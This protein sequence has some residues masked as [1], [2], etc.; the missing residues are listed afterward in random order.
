MYSRSLRYYFAFILLLFGLSH[1][2]L[3]AVGQRKDLAVTAIPASLTKGANVVIRTYDQ[4]V[5]VLDVKQVKITK[6]VIVTLLN[7]LASPHRYLAEM[8]SSL[9]T[10]D[11]IYAT[12]YDATGKQIKEV[13][14]KDFKVAPANIGSEGYSDVRIKGYLIQSADYPLTIEV[15]TV[16]TSLHTFMLPYW[17]PQTEFGED[18]VALESAS[19]TV[20]ATP[21]AGLRYKD[22]NVA[23]PVVKQVSGNTQ[24]S[25]KAQSIQAS[26][27]ESLRPPGIHQLPTVLLAVDN[28]SLETYTGLGSTWSGLGS[29]VWQ[30]NKGRDVLTPSDKVKVHSLTDGISDNRE[31]I[32]ALYKYVQQHTRYVGIE[33]GIGGWQTLDAAFV[34]KN[35]YGDCK[36]LS[37]YTMALLKEAGITSYPALVSAGLRYKSLIREFS[38]SCFNHEILCVPL[39]RDTIWLECTSS[40]AP[41][42]YLG[43]F[44]Q[45]RDV[46]LL[47]PIGG[48]IT[49]TPDYGKADNFLTRHIRAS[50]NNDMECIM[51][52]DSKYGGYLCDQI[53]DHLEH[54]ADAEL[55]QYVSNKFS[56][57]AYTVNDY[58]FDKVQDATV[59]T[60]KETVNIT[61]VGLASQSEKRFFLSLNL[62]P[63]DLPAV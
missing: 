25:W 43:A 33:L 6:H 56:L 14:N 34:G 21:G 61:A 16:V 37:N 23:P 5:D 4:Q 42:G 22:F 44:T 17:S 54:L 40:I 9:N 39:G 58:R 28:I 2:S 38:A 24:W 57:A 31:K 63:L 27:E 46:L 8:F 49:H 3:Y 1:N 59:P 13:R 26:V 10:L 29:F 50:L 30:M 12:V 52:I 41:P 45:N 32:K 18:R 19:L 15:T 7:P 35:Q 47:T 55:K 62:M 36:A 51:K 20:T 48:A 11:D 60:L 53:Q